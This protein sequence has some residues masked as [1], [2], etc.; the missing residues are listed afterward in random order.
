[1]AF[2]RA[3]SALIL[4]LVNST[5]KMNATNRL[6]IDSLN[7]LCRTN[8]KQIDLT[9]N[10]EDNRY[11]LGLFPE[12]LIEKGGESAICMHMDTPTG[13]IPE[14][15]VSRYSDDFLNESIDEKDSAT[16]GQI[17]HSIMESCITIGNLSSA[18]RT[19]IQ[20]GILSEK[21]E[22]NVYQTLQKALQ[23][24]KTT[25]WF[26]G[27][28]KVLTEADIIIPGGDMKR[29]DRIMLKDN[30]AIVVDYK[31]G[32]EDDKKKHI[33]QVQNYVK[34]IKDSGIPDAEG[35]VWYV[36]EG[37]IVAV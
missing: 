5:D 4:F 13:K 9:F 17:Y 31:F 33:K 24:P 11:T 21:D 25:T 19:K 7:T 16:T 22:E 37:D 26:D 18:V 15:R 29:P 20:E 30:T 12:K 36:L 2:T 14:V 3:E 27:Q 28:Y 35:Y 6:I 10:E 32:Q 23:H 8:D 1:M 34:L